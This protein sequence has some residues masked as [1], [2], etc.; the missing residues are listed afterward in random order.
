MAKFDLSM[1]CDPDDRLVGT[2]P[3]Q[4]TLLQQLPVQTMFW[5]ETVMVIS[6][7]ISWLTKSKRGK[8]EIWEW[9]AL[10]CIGISLWVA[11]TFLSGNS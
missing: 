2:H 5:G 1:V 6:F 10:T 3:L 9:I 11:L 8:A 7:G 4:N